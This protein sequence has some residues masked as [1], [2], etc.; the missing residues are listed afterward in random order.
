VNKAGE[1]RTKPVRLLAG[2]R[3]ITRIKGRYSTA[4]AWIAVTA[5][6]FFVALPWI[7]IKGVPLFLINIFAGEFTLFAQHVPFAE[8][9]FYLLPLF[10]LLLF[11]GGC[12]AF[13]G[14]VWC[15]FLCPQTLLTEMLMRPLVEGVARF[16]W[17]GLRNSPLVH[18]RL[19]WKR[20]ALA[21][22]FAL[23]VSAVVGFH[24]VA[25]IAGARNLVTF[26]ASPAM[27]AT[28]AGVTLLIYLDGMF[29]RERF[30]TLVC[31]Y[32]RI[33]SVL[34]DEKTRALGYDAVR[35]EPRGRL[36]KQAS[37]ALGDCVNCGLCVR[38]CPTGIDIRNGPSQLDCISCTRCIDACDGVMESLGRPS[39]LIRFD[40]A[41][42]L[43]QKSTQNVTQKTAS[44]PMRAFLY[45]ALSA[46]SLLATPVI[47][48][49]RDPFSVQVLGTAGRPFV[50]QQSEILNLFTVRI[51]NRQTQKGTYQISLDGASH[52]RILSTA[53]CGPVDAGRD[54]VCPI[55]ISFQ[56]SVGTA[57]PGSGKYGKVRLEI[58]QVGTKNII[59][60]DRTLLGP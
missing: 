46:V 43:I 23:L 8:I 52:E 39:Q 26:S 29:L 36:K 14:R 34:Q 1:F 9:A 27:L 19:G 54:V 58:I 51:R 60:V 12:A 5:L 22:T 20:V 50:Q 38:V 56:K 55:L 45:F 2:I 35:G 59:K 24:G 48:F 6:I 15:G 30:C 53:H 25:W 11:L 4:R 41:E 21:H 10:S 42:N 13:R 33:Q 40:V 47:L 3:A 37:D 44:V 32:A 17:S 7:E 31:P 18:A 49:A 57:I 28:W 16:S